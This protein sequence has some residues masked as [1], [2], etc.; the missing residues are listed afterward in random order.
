MKMF[1]R[2]AGDGTFR[3]VITSYS[4]HYTKLYDATVLNLPD[5]VGYAIPGEFSDLVRY[6]MAHTPNMH[7]A[8]LSIHC[9]N[10]SYNFV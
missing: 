6:V 7:K 2:Q 10:D 8:I 5:T 1:L 9:H 4:I 3:F